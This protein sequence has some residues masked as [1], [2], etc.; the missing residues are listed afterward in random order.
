MEKGH[1]QY[2]ILL[3]TSI[4]THLTGCLKMGVFRGLCPLKR[5][6]GVSP[7]TPPKGHCPLWN[8]HFHV[9]LYPMQPVTT[10]FIQNVILNE[11]NYPEIRGFNKP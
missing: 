6:L 9:A 3:K 2:L 5:G 1:H 10:N 8:P 11:K 7:I 4:S